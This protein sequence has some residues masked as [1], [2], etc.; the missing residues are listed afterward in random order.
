MLD[1]LDDRD[2]R[3]L[4][5]F[6]DLVIQ[7]EG[8]LASG[9]VP[10]WLRERENQG[11]IRRAVQDA[12]LPRAVESSVSGLMLGLFNA[13][14]SSQPRANGAVRKDIKKLANRARSLRNALVPGR[15]LDDTVAALWSDF[16]SI[17]APDDCT[18]LF[19]VD[20]CAELAAALDLFCD[21]AAQVELP[22]H[23]G[24]TRPSV[25]T[26]AAIGLVGLAIEHE[27]A[28]S[29]APLAHL[30]Q[31]VLDAAIGD[32]EARY[33]EE[34]DRPDWYDRIAKDLAERRARKSL[35]DEK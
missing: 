16:D 17:E 7:A 8:L 5:W 25:T 9:A 3:L 1:P 30:A 35:A 32:Y 29:A 28:I 21:R 2:L 18:V 27:P 22:A 31:R 4:G 10:D 12:G 26:L 34:V 6:G 24:G 20:A 33:A 19:W 14:K 23:H 11:E 13:L 15:V